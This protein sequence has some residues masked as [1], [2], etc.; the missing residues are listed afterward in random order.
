M[1]RTVVI[2]GGGIAG[3]TSGLAFARKAWKVRVHEL[4]QQLRILG[5]AI[6]IW[7]NGLR[8]LDAL[9]VLPAVIRDAIPGWRHEKRNHDGSIFAQSHVS[10]RFRLYA[11]SLDRCDPAARPLSGAGR[12]DPLAHCATLRSRRSAASGA[13]VST[14]VR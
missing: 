2:G 6:Y 12:R 4:D 8:M 13:Y 11:L 9:G 10:P 3:L 7:E 14:R 1:T 5:A